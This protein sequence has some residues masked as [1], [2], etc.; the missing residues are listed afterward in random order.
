MC[1]WSGAAGSLYLFLNANIMPQVAEE[2]LSVLRLLSPLTDPEWSLPEPSHGQNRL[3]VALVQL[4][5]VARKLAMSH[6][7]EVNT[8]PHS[9]SGA[10]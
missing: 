5:N 6:T 1:V 10:T 4:Q 9:L 8:K 7:S 2:V 3:D